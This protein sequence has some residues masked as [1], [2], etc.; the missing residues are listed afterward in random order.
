MHKPKLNLLFYAAF[1]LVALIILID[2]A[3]PGRRI[4]DDIINVQKERQQYY[5]AAR[6]YH[7]TYKVTTNEHVFY[8]EEEFAELELL[9]ER[10]AYAVSPIFKEVNW[11]RLLSNEKKTFYSLSRL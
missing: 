1:A 3:W 10:I 2:F 11:Y 6:N 7:Y 8:V 9:K 4:N 5:N